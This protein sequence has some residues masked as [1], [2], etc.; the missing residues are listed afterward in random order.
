MN[1]K[2]LNFSK[3]IMFFSQPIKNPY[4]DNY[5]NRQS[6]L[7]SYLK[8]KDWKI[9]IKKFMNTE[10]LLKGLADSFENR[11]ENYVLLLTTN[12]YKFG[13]SDKV[14]QSYISIINYN[15]YLLFSAIM[16]YQTE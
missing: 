6:T 1:F 2:I 4:G 12:K 13:L 10:A 5:Q 14:I 11:T 15:N 16:L 3:K 9:S 8:K 7:E